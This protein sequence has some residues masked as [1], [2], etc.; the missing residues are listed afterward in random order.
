MSKAPYSGAVSG[1]GDGKLRR[2]RAGEEPLFDV[3]LERGWRV[4][5]AALAIA[6]ATALAGCNKQEETQAAT[7]QVIA[8]VGQDDVTQQELDNELRLDNIPADKRSDQVV[9]TVLG[10][11]L[12]RK[13]L[14]QQAIAAKMDREPTARLDVLRSREQVLAG[15]YVQRE[16]GAKVAAISNN[17]TGAYIAAHPERFAKRQVFQIEQISF[18]PQK[19]ME[20]LAAATKDF[21][22]MDQV[23]AKLN[24]LGIKY[25]RGTA[26][27]DGATIPSEML[28]PLE[29][30]KPDDI[31]FIRSR[32]GGSFFKVR[33]ADG[34]P[35]TGDQADQLAK[36]ELAS[37]LAKK[38]AQATSAAAL[39]AAKFEG[40]YA[41]IM[42]SAAPV[43]TPQAGEAQNAPPAGVAQKAAEGQKEAPKN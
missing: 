14:V 22:T 31:F 39:A 2:G 7:G 27:L 26:A 3:F 29:A 20:S 12:E 16:L 23:E 30:R 37:D 19:D 32:T 41:R 11:I 42:T 9:K 10:R 25:S 5:A 18:P 38:E 13:Y 33:S 6:G 35:L 43:S 8:H 24:D 40:D 1:H 4:G 17:E 36:R 21:K 34:R 15:A 28:K